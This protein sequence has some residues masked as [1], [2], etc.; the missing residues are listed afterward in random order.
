MIVGLCGLLESR[1]ISLIDLG[2]DRFSDKVEVTNAQIHVVIIRL[3]RATRVVS[4][5]KLA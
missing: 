4:D 1:V 2:H 5:I 3:A